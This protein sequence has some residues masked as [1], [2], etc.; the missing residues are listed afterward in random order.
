MTRTNL[1]RTN[2]YPYHITARGNN[3]EEFPCGSL[4][5]WKTFT[6][7]LF[8]QQELHGLLVHA[9]VLMPNHYHLIASTPERD[10]DHVMRDFQSSSTRIINCRTQRTGRIFGSTYHWSVIRDPLHYANVLKYVI[11]NP[12]KAGIS[13]YVAGYPFSSYSGL[14]GSFP[15]P[16]AISNPMMEL[17][18]LIPEDASVRDQWLNKP[19]KAEVNEAIRKGLRREEFEVASDRRTR[20]KL[21]LSF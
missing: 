17:G 18:R 13:N 2:K 11:R 5:A 6:G 4:F 21:D 20:R 9:F 14:V 15:I 10:I 12:V 7:E 19:H 1:L 8:V 3:R 16:L